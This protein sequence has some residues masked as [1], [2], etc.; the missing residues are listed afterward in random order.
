MPEQDEWETVKRLKAKGCEDLIGFVSGP[1]IKFERSNRHIIDLQ[2]EIDD[3]MKYNPFRV[4]VELDDNGVDQHARAH[5]DRPVP[6]RIGAII[7]D[8][9]HNLR[10]SL[11]L[12]ACDLARIAGCNDKQI[13]KTYFPIANSEDAYKRGVVD[14]TSGKRGDRGRDKIRYLRK[15]DQDSISA[16]KPYKGGNDPLHHLHEL[17]ILD[18]HELILPVGANLALHTGPPSIQPSGF[19]DHVYVY[20]PSREMRELVDGAI[21]HTFPVGIPLAHAVGDMGTQ[22]VFGSGTLKGQPVVQSLFDI[23]HEVQQI[24]AKLGKCPEIEA[25]V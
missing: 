10:A 15:Q 7:G 17:D 9:I 21:F 24:I 8:V 1:A 22:L 20:A 14:P 23:G 18:K 16:L 19:D 2:H 4:T 13:R 11:D 6:K 25:D 3:F 5:I 12:L